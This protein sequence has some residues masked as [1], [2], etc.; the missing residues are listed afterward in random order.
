VKRYSPFIRHLQ[1]RGAE[2]AVHSYD[3]I[4][5]KAISVSEAS[6]QLVKAARMFEHFG[7]EVR[8]FRCPYLS[9]TD[10]L[11]SVLPRGLFRYSSN[12][13]VNW[14]ASP[15]PEKANTGEFFNTINRF[16]QPMSALEKVCVPWT[17]SDIT[18]IPISV[19]DDLQLYDGLGLSP[20]EIAQVWSRSLEQTHKRGELFA[21]LFHPEL[22]LIC[23]QPFERILRQARQ[24]RPQVWIARLCDI[25]DWWREK[26]G[27]TVDVRY[28]LAGLHL[29]FNCSARATILC[30]GL[31][32][33][34]STKVWDGPYCQLN[35]MALDVSAEPRPFIGL[36]FKAPDKIVAFLQEQGYILDTSE[37]ASCCGTYLDAAT[38]ATMTSEVAL[39]SFIEASNSPL[40][41]YWRWPNGAKSAMCISGDLDALSLIDYIS[42]LSA[43]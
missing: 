12:I 31:S 42:R 17:Q 9:F 26:A 13:A 35:A 19:P 24:L 1:D 27:F 11:T 36:S 38:L 10:E 25:D 2:I 20:E 14:D 22:A 32:P 43:H 18:E 30:R 6:L 37:T 5:L 40:V 21:P 23:Q 39:V 28:N 15:L 34:A 4:D 33:G 29:D 8:G 3:H 16:Y 7:I 41:R